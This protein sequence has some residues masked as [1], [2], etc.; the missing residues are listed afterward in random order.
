M[1]ILV[2]LD[3]SKFELQNAVIHLVSGTPSS[4][5]EGQIWYDTSDR[6]LKYRNNTTTVVLTDAYVTTLTVDDSTIQNTGTSTA[7]AIQVKALGITNAHIATSAAIALSKLATDPLARANHTGTQTASTISDFDTQ[8]RTSRL[9]QMA[10]PTSAV[11]MNSQRI[12]SVA[13]PTSANDAANKSYVDNVS[14]GLDPK[15]SVRAATASALAAN[16][17]SNGSSG[18]GAT[19]TGNA[20]GALAAVDGVTPVVNDRLLVK[21]ESAGANNGIYAVTQVGSGGT[22][23]ILTRVTDADTAA[24]VSPGMFVFVEEGTANADSGWILSTDGAVTIGTTALTFVQFTGA[25]QITAGAGLTKTAN[26]LDV[27]GTAGRISVAAD[28]VDIDTAYAGQATI[29]TLGTITTGTWSA[30]TIAV[31]KG[32]T[33]A[34]TPAGARSNL[35]VP[36]KYTASLTGSSTTYTINQS[37]H[38][39]AA[40]RSNIVQVWDTATGEVVYAGVTSSSGGNI[41]ITFGAAPTSG[42]YSVTIIG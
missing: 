5:A 28:S 19:L 16:T 10:A 24:E 39:C 3:L 25:G 15:G 26:T 31:N 14:A 9:D 20:N 18:V 29:V 13:T 21:N 11:S 12:T 33:G 6:K 37:T 42:Q 38:L 8:V 34:T 27:V 7:P 17:Y 4:P 36:G 32:G 30:A 35:G 23:Y 41:T 40:D 22:P 1:K 2:S